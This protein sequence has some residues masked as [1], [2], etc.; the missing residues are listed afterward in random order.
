M[1]L[2]LTSAPF[3][4]LHKPRGSLDILSMMVSLFCGPQL[5]IPDCFIQ[6]L[7]IIEIH[8]EGHRGRDKSVEILL[9]HFLAS[10]SQI[11]G[12]VCLAMLYLPGSQ[13]N[14][15]QCRLVYATTYTWWTM[16][17]FVLGLPCTQCRVDSIFVVV[18]QFSKMPHFIAC[19]KTSDTSQISHLFFREV[20]R[21]HG[22]LHS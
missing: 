12:K 16:V 20:M 3:T 8:N 2:I 9:R 15:Y 21:L 5:C 17:D 18:D 22:I 6:E 13:G 7:I 1:L 14:S 4:T 10:C 19:R 11:Y